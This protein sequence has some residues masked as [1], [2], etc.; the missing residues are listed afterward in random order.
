MSCG[1]GVLLC[2][3]V[4]AALPAAAE[5]RRLAIVVGNNAGG[6]AMP[7]LRYAE[8]DAGKMARVLIE[9]GD[10]GMDDVMLLQGRHVADLE[11]AILDAKER[12]TMFKRSPETRTVLIFYFSG[13]SDGEAIEMGLEKLPYGRLKSMLLGTG[14]DLRVAIVDACKSGAGFLQKG[15]KPAEPFTIKLTDTLVASGDAF[16]TSSAADESALESSEVMG[17]FFTHNLISGLRGAADAS[18]DKLVTLAEAYRYAFDHTV[19]ATAMMAVGAQHPSYDYRL[20]GQGELVLASLVKPSASLLLP[21]GADR[22]MVTDLS[23]DQVVVEVAT[24]SARQIALAPGSY[25]LRLFKGGQSWGG[26]V[27]LPEGAHKTIRWDELTLMTSS[28]VVAA[29]GGTSTVS[30]SIEV[31]RPEENKRVLSVAVGALKGI[32][33]EAQWKGQVRVGFEPRQGPGLSIALLGDTTGAAAI[34]ENGV[35]ARVGFRWAW[36]LGVVWLSLGA[37]VGL[38]VFWQTPGRF[39]PSPDVSLAGVL[40]P[41]GGAR[42]KLAGP[43]WLSLDGDLSVMLLKLNDKLDAVVR[44]SFTLGFAFAF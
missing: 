10:V 22:S 16:I 32:A 24:G 30:Q 31:T 29:K 19:T 33:N 34:A 23:R 2:V 8:S 38:A 20:S 43:L 35:H 5:S 11:R 36:E 26:R 17:S 14:A 13:H 12:V 37:E 4:L 7:P 6:P 40:A 3:L 44:P 21:E 15:G 9:L 27:V 18:G 1:R 39:S 41:R 42:L 25:G 28:I